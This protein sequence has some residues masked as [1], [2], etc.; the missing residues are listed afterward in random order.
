MKKYNAHP[1]YSEISRSILEFALEK[2]IDF[3]L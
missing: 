1:T 2:P 3:H